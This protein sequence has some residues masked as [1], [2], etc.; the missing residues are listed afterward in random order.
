MG[1]RRF[2]SDRGKQVWGK[3]K[4]EEEKSGKRKLR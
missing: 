1:I 3:G 4:E 2:G